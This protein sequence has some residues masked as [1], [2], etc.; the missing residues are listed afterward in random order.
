MASAQLEVLTLRRLSE[1][2]GVGRRRHSGNGRSR[3]EFTSVHEY[4]VEDRQESCA[5]VDCECI[6]LH[7]SKSQRFPY[8]SSKTATVPYDSTFGSRTNVIPSEIILW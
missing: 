6:E 5:R 7:S 3:K 2:V 8:K 4:L 1:C